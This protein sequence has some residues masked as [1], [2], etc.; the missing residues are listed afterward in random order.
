[1]NFG[2]TALTC[3]ILGI[4]VGFFGSK[5]IDNVVD[6][7]IFTHDYQLLD[8]DGNW[9]ISDEL[10]QAHDELEHEGEV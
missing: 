7:D 2:R 10:V 5:L 4:V 8:E 9:K 1:M 3:F 6:S